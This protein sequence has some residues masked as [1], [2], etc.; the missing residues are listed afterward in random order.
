VH[1]W[2]PDGY[3]EILAAER[4]DK[5]RAEPFDAIDFSVSELFGEEDDG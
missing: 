4:G 2:G 3:A 1:R 5:A